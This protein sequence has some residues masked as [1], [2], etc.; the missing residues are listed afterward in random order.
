M[1]SWSSLACKQSGEIWTRTLVSKTRFSSIFCNHSLVRDSTAK[2]F[3]VVYQYLSFLKSGALWHLG[4]SLVLY[5]CAPGWENGDP[6]LARHAA[7][8]QELLLGDDEDDGGEL[9][10]VLPLERIRGNVFFCSF[11][12]P[13]ASS[14]PI[15][16]SIFC[17]VTKE[18][19][20][21]LAQ[22]RKVGTL[23]VL[24]SS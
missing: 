17:L 10:P 6:V 5:L 2:F 24:I 3:F 11:T 21:K 22:R 19:K 14:A 16:W 12:L 7:G 23:F 9:E 4:N 20:H 8:G 1:S 15:T 18:K 13:L